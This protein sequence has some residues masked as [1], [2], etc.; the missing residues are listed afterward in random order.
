MPCLNEKLACLIFRAHIRVGNPYYHGEL[1]GGCRWWVDAPL[2][3]AFK[4]RI[5]RI[6]TTR[7]DYRR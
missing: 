6:T 7:T 1:C 4:E 5:A 2:D 3:T